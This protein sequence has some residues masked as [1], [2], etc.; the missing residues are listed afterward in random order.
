MVIDD[1]IIVTELSAASLIM[2]A[3]W[4]RRGLGSKYFWGCKGRER[5]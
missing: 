4:G 1:Q 2:S 5:W 3:F